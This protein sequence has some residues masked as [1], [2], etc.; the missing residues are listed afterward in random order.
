LNF[1]ELPQPVRL[2]PEHPQYPRDL[3]ALGADAPKVLWA[4]GS[5]DVFNSRPRVAIVGTRRST[6]YGRRVTLELATALARAGACIVSGLATGVDGF[7]HAAALDVGAPTIAVLGT[8]LDVSFP[9]ANVELQRSIAL[10][11][12]LLTEL[13]A[14]QR[15]QRFTFPRRNRIIAAL[16]QL[17]IVVEAGQQSGALITAGHALD[18]D[19]D[20]AGVPGP[21]DQPQSTGV[22]RLI[23]DGAQMLTSIEDALALAGLQ[24]AA[25]TP[26]GDPDG[27][28]ARVWRALA[29]GPLHLDNLCHQS[30]LPAAQCMAAVTALEIAGSVECAL[31]GEIRRR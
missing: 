24:T 12:L 10:R 25:R 15:G 22:N 29:G 2:T 30:G 27:D 13:E 20:V 17:T 1:P 5:L 7:A 14:E 26:R 4:R 9:R 19:R 28:E 11:G 3:D 16:A 18:L 21:I 8:G 31:T 6:A 23:R